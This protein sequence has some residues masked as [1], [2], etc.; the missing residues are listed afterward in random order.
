LISK[1]RTVAG[2]TT[3][4]VAGMATIGALV[5]LN[6]DDGD[7]GPTPQIVA[8]AEG[9]LVVLDADDGSIVR[10]L[11]TGEFDPLQEIQ[12]PSV[13]QDGRDVYFERGA[14]PACD[15]PEIVSMPVAGGNEVFVRRGFSPMVSPDGSTLAYSTLTAPERCPDAIA[16]ELVVLDLEAGAERR[17]SLSAGEPWPIGWATDSRLVVLQMGGA[18]AI[19]LTL[20]RSPANWVP[21]TPRPSCCLVR[22]LTRRA[23]PRRVNS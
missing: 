15:M 19:M 4:A 2:I 7:D 10:T 3:L 21:R 1:P 20:G 17:W 23:L 14:G 16:F 11:A 12:G 5:L 18:N 6:R 8:V 13:T 9:A 22:R